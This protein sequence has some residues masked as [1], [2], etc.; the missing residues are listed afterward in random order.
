MRLFVA[1]VVLCQ[2]QS[3]SK[4]SQTHRH[5][6]LTYRKCVEPRRL[7][8]SSNFK[9]LHSGLLV[10]SSYSLLAFETLSLPYQLDQGSALSLQG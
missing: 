4:A 3:Q 10:D 1:L 6:L 7:T 9:G 2:C 5:I 8:S